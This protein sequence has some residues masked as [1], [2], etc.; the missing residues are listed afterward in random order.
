MLHP[1]QCGHKAIH[2]AASNNQQH[3]I[4][5]LLSHK[6]CDKNEP[7]AYKE[8]PLHT[9]CLHGHLDT[10][11]LLL[12][13]RADLDARDGLGST[14]LHFSAA[15]NSGHLLRFFVEEQGCGRL[16]DVTNKVK[17][18][19]VGEARCGDEEANWRP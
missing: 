18:G 10:A 7:S 9:A 17:Y 12:Q 1:L 6:L 2:S 11:R 15:A 3:I 19:R 4:E 8:T 13:H 5:Y 16:L 14:V